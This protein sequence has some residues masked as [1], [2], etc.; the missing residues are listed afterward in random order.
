[1]QRITLK[2]SHFQIIGYVEIND[3]GKKTLKDSHFMIKGYYEPRQNVTKD[4]NFRIVG[5]GDIL[6]SLL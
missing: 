6:T 1:M 3:D 2:D 5:Y 4:S